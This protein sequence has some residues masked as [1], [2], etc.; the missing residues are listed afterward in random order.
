VQKP[1][2]VEAVTDRS[3]S[4]EPAASRRPV[5][6]EVPESEPTPPSQPDV[7][8]ERERETLMPSFSPDLAGNYCTLINY[9]A[10]QII[11]KCIIY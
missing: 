8:L 9:S 7:E 2:E 1:A 10:V 5:W 6:W 11:S 4:V 3:V